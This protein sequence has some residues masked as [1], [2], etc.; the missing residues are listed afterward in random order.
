MLEIL[1]ITEKGQGTDS[2]DNGKKALKTISK[3]FQAAPPITGPESQEERMVSWVRT[4]L[5]CTTL[6]GCSASWPLQFQPQPKGPKIQLRLQ[7]Q[8]VQAINLGNFHGVLSLSGRRV[9]EG[10]R[11]GSLYQISENA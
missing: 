6:K 3:A 5:P 4:P 10:R 2:P 9:Q 1:G 7:L 8:R 11:L